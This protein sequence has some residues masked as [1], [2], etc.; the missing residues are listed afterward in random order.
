MKV[1]RIHTGFETGLCLALCVVDDCVAENNDSEVV[2]LKIWREIDGAKGTYRIT[3]FLWPPK[4]CRINE[5]RANHKGARICDPGVTGL[6]SM[7]RYI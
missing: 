3:C 7:T 6:R 5:E 2:E 1:A 4:L